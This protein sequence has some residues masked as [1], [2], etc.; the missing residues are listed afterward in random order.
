MMKRPSIPKV[1][2]VAAL[3][4]VGLTLVPLPAH[5]TT[6]A[7]ISLWPTGYWGKDPALLSCTGDGKSGEK[8]L[9]L[10]DFM[11]TLKRF[12]YFGMTLAVFVF[13]PI[14]ILFGGLMMIFGGASPSQ[15]QYGKR[16]LTGTVIAVA[17]VLGAF[18]IVNTFYT[19]I[20]QGIGGGS[21]NWYNFN[22][23]P[24]KMPGSLYDCGN[25][26]VPLNPDGTHPPC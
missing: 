2:S 25:K 20:V 18:L 9:S 23:Q 14:S 1:F 5:A 3:F 22:C 26:V 6:I 24:E 13:A 10:C 7:N 8:C 19:Y 4:L 12:I 21:G 16:I 17:I 15:Y 11:E